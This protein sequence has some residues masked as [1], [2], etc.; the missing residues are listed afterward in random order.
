MVIVKT[1]PPR[2]AFKEVWGCSV[3]GFEERWHEYV[4]QNYKGP[5]DGKSKLEKKRP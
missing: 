4:T 2:E 3:P 1:R 5:G